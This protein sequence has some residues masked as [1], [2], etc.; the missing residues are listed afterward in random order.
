MEELGRKI[1]WLSGMLVGSAITR[2]V[3]GISPHYGVRIYVALVLLIAAWM[4]ILLR[5]QKRCLNRMKADLTE[6]ERA[7]Y[8]AIMNGTIFR[9]RGE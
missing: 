4:L 2:F 9:N 1:L 3:T 8:E 7:E 6:Q 5:E